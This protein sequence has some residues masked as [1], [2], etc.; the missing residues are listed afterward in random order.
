MDVWLQVESE[1]KG[2][3]SVRLKFQDDGSGWP[4]EVLR[5]QSRHVELD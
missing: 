3:L 5:G 2:R 4:D 1:A